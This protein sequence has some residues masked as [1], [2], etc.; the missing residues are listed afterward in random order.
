VTVGGIFQTKEGTNVTTNNLNLLVQVRFIPPK[1]PVKET[2]ILSYFLD[3]AIW[4]V[5]LGIV[6]VVIIALY[7]L[8]QRKTKRQE[9]DDLVAFATY[10]EAQKKARG[11]GAR[12]MDR[13]SPP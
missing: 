13:A 11:E 9:A 8:T 2:T 6:I 4:F 3:H 7:L 12:D 1:P 5:G 10:V